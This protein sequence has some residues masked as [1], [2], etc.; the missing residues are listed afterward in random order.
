VVFV[1]A[2]CYCCNVDSFFL[3]YPPNIAV[4]NKTSSAL[5]VAWEDRFSFFFEVSCFVCDLRSV[6]L[7]SE[8][9]RTQKLI[10]CQRLFSVRLHVSFEY[11]AFL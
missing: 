11:L 2:K 4:L 8:Y 10:A 3:G 6:I 1:I 5:V 7:F 9:S